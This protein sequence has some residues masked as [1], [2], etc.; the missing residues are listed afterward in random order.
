MADIQLGN[1]MWLLL[2]ILTAFLESLKDVLSKKNLKHIDEYI[3]GWS[4]NAFPLPFIIVTLYFLGFP[5]LKKDFISALLIS[6]SLN[7]IAVLLYVKALK[8]SDLSLTLPLLAF[9]PL[10]LLI[11]SQLIVNEFPSSWG[12]VGVLLIIVG[13]YILNFDQRQ[14]GYLNPF[15]ALVREKG[16]RMMLV[17]AFIWSITSN[18]DKIGVQNSSPLFWAFSLYSFISVGF[19][20]IIFLK[21]RKYIVKIRSRFPSLTLIGIVNAGKLYSQMSAISLTLVA[22]VVSIKRTSV[23]FGILF[24]YLIFHEKNIKERLIGSLI[25]ILGVFLISLS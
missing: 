24:G 23:L 18:F 8:Y 9:T 17:V 16:A 4:L 3:V 5:E 2:S 20:P 22:Y 25:M 15:K 11:T 13:S 10:F 7:I 19:L 1:C 21:S 14:K 12:L 6:G